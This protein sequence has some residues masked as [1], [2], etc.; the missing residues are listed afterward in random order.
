MDVTP[1]TF[2]VEEVMGA[3]RPRHMR[4]GHTYMP[5]GYAAYK[6]RIADAYRAAGGIDYGDSPVSVT[7]DIMRELPGSRPKRVKREA[8]TVRPDVDNV[9][10]GVMDALNGI[11]YR[12][13]SQVVSLSVLKCDRTRS[14]TRMRVAVRPEV[15]VFSDGGRR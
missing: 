13:D 11:A 9:A 1:S 4:N 3:P 14:P 8:D 6:R 15:G 7:I 10:K 2:T 12:D 5:S